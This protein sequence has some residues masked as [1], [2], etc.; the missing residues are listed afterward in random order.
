MPSNWVATMIDMHA[1]LHRLLDRYGEGDVVDEYRDRMDVVWYDMSSEE[2]EK[3][4]QYFKEEARMSR[5]SHMKRHLKALIASTLVYKKESRRIRGSNGG[6]HTTACYDYDKESDRLR[7]MYLVYGF[8][9]GKSYEAMERT[10]HTEPN[11]RLF[12]EIAFKHGVRKPFIW[13]KWHPKVEDLVKGI[14]VEFRQHLKKKM[15]DE[16]PEPANGWHHTE[17]E[18]AT[19]ARKVYPEGEAPQQLETYLQMEEW[20]RDAHAHFVSNPLYVDPVEQGRVAAAAG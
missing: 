3:V 8:L 20:L 12:R 15:G 19:L 11:W 7:T 13:Q 10:T 5:S 2:H 18:I 14:P 4:R 17:A 16:W 1:N 6:I 9:R